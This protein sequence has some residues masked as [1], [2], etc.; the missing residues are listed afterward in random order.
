M[1]LGAMTHKGKLDLIVNNGKIGLVNYSRCS[2]LVC[3]VP[4]LETLYAGGRQFDNVTELQDAV[5]NA[6]ENIALGY[7][8]TLCHSLPSCLEPVVESKWKKMSHG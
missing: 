1:V 3:Q 6:L 5:M 4:G 8:Q 7:L 2:R